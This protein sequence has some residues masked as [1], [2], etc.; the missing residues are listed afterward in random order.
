VAPDSQDATT[1]VRNVHDCSKNWLFR[2]LTNMFSD[3][4]VIYVMLKYLLVIW[5][6]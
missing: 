1:A 5:S 2:C 3:Q 6:I 4:E